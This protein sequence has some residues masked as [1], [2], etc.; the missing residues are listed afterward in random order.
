[1]PIVKPSMI[2]EGI[3]TALSYENYREQQK[4]DFDEKFLE[5]QKKTRSRY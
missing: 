3:D 4:K 1:M 5:A 2:D